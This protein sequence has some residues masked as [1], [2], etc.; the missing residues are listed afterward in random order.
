[1]SDVGGDSSW[2]FDDSCQNQAQSQYAGVSGRKPAGL[3]V[4]AVCENIGGPLNVKVL[5]HVQHSSDNSFREAD[6][7]KSKSTILRGPSGQSQMGRDGAVMK[8]WH[9]E[10][11][12]QMQSIDDECKQRSAGYR[13]MNTELP[14]ACTI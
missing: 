5:P 1:M 14:R 13:L 7:N 6:A 10:S 4:C 11:A 2:S 12:W 3:P 8:Y 9:V